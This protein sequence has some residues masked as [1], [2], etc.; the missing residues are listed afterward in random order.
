[1]ASDYYAA[2]LEFASA[3]SNYAYG[4]IFLLAFSEA[5]PVI[6]TFVPGSTLVFGISA[7]ATKA[8]A[9]PWLLLVA[10]TAGAIAGDGGSFWLGQRFSREIL[11]S[12]PLTKYP[13][14]IAQ[15]EKFIAKYGAAGVFLARFTAVVRAF[16]P[17]V[18]GILKMPPRQFY[19]ANVLSA[20]VWAPAHVFPGVVLA[21]VSG[22]TDAIRDQHGIL[23]IA[24]LIVV[25]LIGFAAHWWL[26]AKI[27]VK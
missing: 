18:A 16:V 17:L 15:S 8:G 24:G 20:V 25:T 6:G 14:F 3:H 19:A 21:M 26:K 4:M 27:K 9:D 23:V 13:H 12:W 22:M 5:V 2:L 11:C 10:A 1:M 7:L